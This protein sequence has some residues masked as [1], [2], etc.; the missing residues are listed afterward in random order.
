[1]CQGCVADIFGSIAGMRPGLTRRRFLATTVGAAAV[2][3]AAA[4]ALAASPEGA[5]LIFRGG[6]II[7]M[8]G[9]SR[10]VEA[11]AVKNGRVAAVGA[12]DAVMGLESAST[13][14]VDLD[15]RALLPGFIDPH[16]HTVT[17]ALVNALFTDCGYTKYKSRDALLAMFRDKAAKT[18][19]GKWLLFTSF[20]NLLQGGDLMMADLDAVSK[21]HPIL[22]YY[23]NMHTAAG[24]AAAFAAAK[25]PADIGNLPGGGRFGRD[26]AGK[27]NGMIYEESALKKFAVAIPKITPQLAGNAVVDWL[28]INASYGNTSVH[29]AGVLV[30]GNLLEGYE[31]VA[32]ISPCRASIS[33]MYESMEDAEPYK[34]YGHGALATQIPNTMLTIYAMK[35]VGDGS[36]QTKTAAQTV[37]YLNDT[38]KGRPNFDGQQLKAMVAEVKAQGWPVSIHC[39]GDETLDIALDAIEAAYGAYPLTGVNRIEHC[40]ITRPEQIERMAKL[41]VQPSFLM[42]HVYFYG[43]AYRDQ[44]FGPERAARMD[45]AADCVRLGLPFTIHTDAPCSNIGTLQLVQAAV[46]RKCS[47]DGSVV[48]PDQAVSLTEALRAVTSHAAGQ[49]G[50]ADQLGTLE[51]GKLADLTILE[52]DPYTVDPD[53]LMNIKV[54]QTWVGGR[55]MFG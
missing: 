23:I 44:L 8:A 42:N 53:A 17:G 50:M 41:G 40:T 35:I 4:P 55:K 49:I 34:K 46:T 9:D 25:I 36:N 1:M 20:D 32:A 47:V 38:D 43:A 10:T 18:P 22:V 26:G 45:P 51:S 27:R 14:I 28:K 33:L 24:N 21:D 6:P 15:G 19:A 52:K 37:P 39:N 12:A 11:L 13:E 31:R 5:D 30:F 48:G 29:E 2:A 7:P 16:Q 3:P 54:S